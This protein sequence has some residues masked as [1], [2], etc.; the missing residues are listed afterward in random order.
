MI[1]TNF[2]LKAD[3]LMQ[4]RHTGVREL[5]NICHSRNFYPFLFILQRFMVS[6]HSRGAKFSNTPVAYGDWKWSSHYRVH[7]PYKGHLPTTDISTCS[8]GVRNSEVPLYTCS[9]MHS[10]LSHTSNSCKT[11]I[12]VHEMHGRMHPT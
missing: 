4:D 9:A 5:K 8:R 10:T 12:G 7:S 11:L 1:N 3:S 6:L 2:P